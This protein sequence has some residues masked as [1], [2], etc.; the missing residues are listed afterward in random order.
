MKLGLET[1]VLLISFL[2]YMT[3]AGCNFYKK[4]YPHSLIWFSYSLSQIG[5]MW[6]EFTK[7]N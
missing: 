2:A 5:F 6:Y 7:S 3:M 1:V 4:D